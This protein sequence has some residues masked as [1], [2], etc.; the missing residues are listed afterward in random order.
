LVPLLLNAGAR[1]V[2]APL[3]LP[4]PGER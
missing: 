1:A 2:L 3:L 4:R